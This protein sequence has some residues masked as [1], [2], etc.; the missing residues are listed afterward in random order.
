VP[1]DFTGGVTISAGTLQVGNND[2]AGNLP[3]NGNV[4]DNSALV[5]ARSD[6]PAFGGVISGTGTVTQN[7]AGT[8]TLSGANT[9]AGAVTVAQG[10]LQIGNGSALGATNGITT[11][12]NGATL[13]FLANA[14]NIGLEPVV[15]SGSGVGGGGAI[16]NSSGSATFVGPN[17]ARVT[18]AGD[19]IFGGTGRWDLRG[20]TTSNP[21][22]ASLSTGGIARKLTK[23][24]ANQVGIVGVSVDPALGDIEIQGG[25]LDIEA[26]TTSLGNTASNLLVDPGATLQMFAI[27][28][29]L[30]KVITLGGDGA[31]NTL[32]A[33]S[34]SNNIVGPMAITNDCI[35]NVNNAAVSLTLNNVITGP[36]KI[37]KVGLGLLTLSGNSPSYAGGLQLNN[38][39]VV[40]SGTVSNALGMTAG[41]GKFTLNGTVLGTAGV[42]NSAGS[43]VAGSGTS[44]GLGDISGTLNPGDTNVAGTL[45]FGWLILEPG[46]NLNYDLGAINTV[47]SGTNDLIVVNGDLTVNGNSITINALGLLQ[48]G[49][50]YRLFNYTGNL[51]WNGDL[52]VNN[53]GSAT[54]SFAIN[55]NTPGQVNVVVTGGGPPVW[56]GGSLTD[57][58]W[59]D[60]ANWNGISIFSGSP[61]YFGG[62]VRLNNTNDSNLDTPYS[63]ILFIPGAGP[64]VLNGNPITPTTSI[65]NSSS[66]PQTLD[67]G[68]D[69]NTS[70]TLDGGTSGLVVG[71]GVTNT[72]VGTPTTSTLAGT[73]TLTNLLASVDPT[74]TNTLAMTSSTA[75]WTL[76][77]NAASALITVPW[78]FDIRAGTFNFGTASSAP[79]VS[80]TTVNGGPQDQEVGVI[81]GTSGTFNMVNGTLSTVSRLNTALGANST[82]IVNQVG[83]TFN[84]GQQFQGANGANANEL[85]VVN[86]SGGTMNIGAGTG[87]FYVCS[88]GNGTLTVSGS[89]ALNCGVLDVSRSILSGTLGTVNLNGGTITASRVGTATA[90]SVATSTGSSATFNFNGGTLTASGASTTFIQGSIVAPI[91]PVGC[92]VK[93]GGAIIDDGGFAISILEPLQHDSTLGATRDGGLTKLGTGT[94]ALIATNTYTG[95]TTVSNGT[96]AVNGSIGATAVTV[97]TNGAL[98][99]TGTIGSNVTVNAGGSLAPAGRGLI[100]K[101]TV[102]GNVT[103]Q[104]GATNAVDVNKSLASS[105]LLLA[106]NTTA[107]TITYA[108]TLAVTNLAGVL[109]GGD[110]FKLFSASN[111]VGSFTL[112]PAQPAIG[113]KWDTSQLNVNGTLRITAL[114]RPG[115]TGVIFSGGNVTVGGTNG[116]AGFSYRV[117]GSTNVSAPLATWTILGTNVFDGSGNFSFSTSATNA[118][119]FFTIQAL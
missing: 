80:S 81:A 59:N 110:S 108:G 93:S 109:A 44:I 102:A 29:L 88:R 23:I 119:Q 7:G 91:I 34:G 9:F 43:I 89:G 118:M 94:L 96:L 117:L 3:A 63:D 115:I 13:D 84:I 97:A 74:G 92:I 69:F 57:A 45:T 62:N 103:L 82:G 49:A 36:G 26:A 30:N 112:Q 71:G 53:Q 76:V 86:V 25:I 35:F 77:D 68:L 111:Y 65:R 98:A 18:L 105:D 31:A 75:N 27:T 32:S 83:G 48:T 58:N 47:G 6:N 60:P 38:G 17:I 22:L 16:I 21:N 37:T 15:V 46:A 95:G 8:L 104:A 39:S 10:T 2:T 11:V 67:L 24:G 73:G 12:A 66:N 28:N 1:N 56:N 54:Y 42:T 87:Q 70:F 85:S 78:A 14:N 106:T 116:T 100:G 101:L 90:N 107:T 52:S 50:P 4:V 20:S 55:T 113:L 40:V 99:G 79:K 33:T 114:P 72:A 51:I 64:F 19:T 61:L 5:F 41:A